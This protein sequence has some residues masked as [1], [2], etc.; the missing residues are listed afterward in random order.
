MST[1]LYQGGHLQPGMRRCNFAPVVIALATMHK[2]PQSFL[3]Y[4]EAAP[5]S[6]MA[7]GLALL[8][9]LRLVAVV[10]V[11]FLALTLTYLMKFQV[12]TLLCHHVLLRL[13]LFVFLLLMFRKILLFRILLLLFAVVRL[14]RNWVMFII[15]ILT[16]Y[17]ISF[18]LFFFHYGELIFLYEKTFHS[19]KKPFL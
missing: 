10:F 5:E 11:L 15:F 4:V 8:Q 2:D 7:A 13:Q 16:K 3:G 12:Q 18:I 19:V 17:C 9:Q 1:G 6:V 14:P